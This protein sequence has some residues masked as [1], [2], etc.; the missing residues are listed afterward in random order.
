[1]AEQDKQKEKEKGKRIILDTYVQK[2]KPAPEETRPS[3]QK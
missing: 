1:M 3:N 2:V